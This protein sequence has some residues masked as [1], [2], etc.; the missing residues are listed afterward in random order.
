M[1][2][3]EGVALAMPI[4]KEKDLLDFL[5]S[6]QVWMALCP[7]LLPTE[8][9]DFLSATKW[10]QDCS[11]LWE[12][13]CKYHRDLP[14][15]THA[16]CAS[17]KSESGSES[18]SESES[19]AVSDARRSF[20]HAVRKLHYFCEDCGTSLDSIF[21]L[22]LFSRCCFDCDK[23]TLYHRNPYALSYSADDDGAPDDN[24]YGIDWNH[25]MLSGDG[26]L[27]AFG[28]S[29][30]CGMYWLADRQK[31]VV[32]EGRLVDLATEMRL[33]KL[34]LKNHCPCWNAGR[35]KYSNKAYV[36]HDMCAAH[37]GLR[38]VYF[39]ELLANGYLMSDGPCLPALPPW[40]DHLPRTLRSLF[41]CAMHSA[42]KNFDIGDLLPIAGTSTSG[43]GDDTSA[44]G[45][46][47]AGDIAVGN[48]AS[49]DEEGGGWSS[50]QHTVALCRAF[51]EEG[52]DD[53]RAAF[54]DEALRSGE[55]QEL[56]AKA[57]SRNTTLASQL[58]AC[59]AALE[60][61]HLGLEE[62]FH[63][64]GSM[65]LGSHFPGSTHYVVD[66]QL[67]QYAAAIT[68]ELY[69]W[70]DDDG[71]EEEEEGEEEEEEADE[72]EGEGDDGDGDIEFEGSEGLEFDEFDGDD[73]EGYE[74]QA[75]LN[76]VDLDGSDY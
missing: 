46:S 74:F 31:N 29:L 24:P 45:T 18:E 11:K 33:E 61:Y 43:T 73:M 42:I 32:R 7:Y 9:I 62:S 52:V 58:V 35:F 75:D 27:N 76:G 17:F 55:W 63:S 6:K 25:K 47:T 20:V 60:I 64:G 57:Q 69:T 5:V 8:V 12:V 30:S 48:G 14:L 15:D 54:S 13:A 34:F 72:G 40:V 23:N 39:E 44:T 16:L 65:L 71:D 2:E 3:R 37:I 19:V 38:M 49:L 51:L 21:G 50:L 26:T 68:G 67:E 36:L 59:E 66:E 41:A 56:T 22:F 4:T 28:C 1:P 53:V 10:M 70:G